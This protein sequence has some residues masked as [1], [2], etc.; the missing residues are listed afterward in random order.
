MLRIGKNENLKNEIKYTTPD[1]INLPEKSTVKDLGVLFN[2][3]G[4]FSDHISVKAAKARGVAGLILRTFIT[5]EP[6][7]LMMLFKALAIPIMEYGSIIWSP[8]KRG[9]INEIES[10]QRAFTS[11]LEGMKELNYHQ[12]LRELKIY[13]LERRRERYDLLYAYKILQRSVPNIG[14]QFKWCGRRGRT[15][16]PPPVKKNSSEHAK[17]LRHNTYRAR[18]SRVFNSLP[19]EIRNIP[20]DTPLV[21]IKS[22][23]DRYFATIRDEPLLPGY[24]TA[25]VSNSIQHQRRTEESPIRM[26][27]RR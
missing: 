20:A 4:D 21:R 9:E 25:A 17:T 16:V 1:G 18:V 19:A 7:P 11:K 24:N 12:R 5:R 8:H 27:H 13:S 14:L 6:A 15:L 22:M 26:I 2:N 3:K 23:L 10:V